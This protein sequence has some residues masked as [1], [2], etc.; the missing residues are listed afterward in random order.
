[1]LSYTNAGHHPGILFNPETKKTVTLDTKDFFIGCFKNI[2]YKTKEIKVEKND[3]LLLFT[4]GIVEAR[5]RKRQS[6][7]YERLMKCIDQFGGLSP[8]DFTVKITEDVLLFEDGHPTHDDKAVLCIE[9][10]EPLL[11]KKIEG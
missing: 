10:L 3:R 6:Y 7:G 8:A 2:E 1:M 9:F 11:S 4:D 5:N